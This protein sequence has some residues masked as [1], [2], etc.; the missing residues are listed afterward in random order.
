MI[1]SAR[2]ER[3]GEAY[4]S[5]VRSAYVD[6]GRTLDV[7]NESRFNG[8]FKVAYVGQRFCLLTD[9]DH[10]SDPQGGYLRDDAFKHV[11]PVKTRIPSVMAK[12]LQPGDHL[13]LEIRKLAT[14]DIWVPAE[15]IGV[16]P[17]AEE[18][19]VYEDDDT[20]QWESARRSPSTPCDRPSQRETPIGRM[21]VITE[22][23]ELISLGDGA[24]A[25]SIP[26]LSD[27]MT[28]QPQNTVEQEEIIPFEMKRRH[29]FRSRQRDELPPDGFDESLFTD[30]YFGALEVDIGDHD[31]GLANYEE[32]SDVDD[33]TETET[34]S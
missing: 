18:Q 28:E 10:Q 30:A 2:A 27:T 15:C 12:H 14:E 34:E 33:G 22:E 21:D 6:R 26:P 19:I 16:F 20:S 23:L 24:R 31:L 29:L 5:Y 1:R 9:W 25:S 3:V 13:D 4:A 8:G 17:E 7:E 11:D 32:G